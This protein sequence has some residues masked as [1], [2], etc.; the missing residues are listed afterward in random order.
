MG[1]GKQWGKDGAVIR[2]DIEEVGEAVSAFW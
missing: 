2:R 1:E